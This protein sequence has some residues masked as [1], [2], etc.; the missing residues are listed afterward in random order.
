MH[1]NWFE[2]PKTSKNKNDAYDGVGH[3]GQF[4]RRWC[5]GMI[6]DS[7]DSRGK[8]GSQLGK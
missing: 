5:R 4:T 1:A 7:S 6:L 8:T 3:K 2:H